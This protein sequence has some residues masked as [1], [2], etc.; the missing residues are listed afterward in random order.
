MIDCKKY[1][2]NIEKAMFLVVRAFTMDAERTVETTQLAPA[3]LA[4]SANGCRQLKVENL[5][6]YF[7]LL[8]FSGFIFAHYEL[9]STLS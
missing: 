2:L 4:A 5:Y 6:F 8:V 9:I 3:R 1:L 7:F